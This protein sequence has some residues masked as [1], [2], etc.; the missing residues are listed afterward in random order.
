[1]EWL[2]KT[3]TESTATFKVL[4]SPVP[5]HLEAKPGQAGRDTW[6]GFTDEREEIF[7]WI[8]DDG[9]EGVVLLAADRH[10]S[11]AWVTER[12]DSYDLYEFQSSQFTNQHTHPVMEESLFGYNEKNS[13][14]LLQFDTTKDDPTVTYRIVDINGKVQESFTLKHSMLRK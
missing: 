4:V 14:G 6:A 2:Q 3:L 13:F 8:R 1:M 9:I 12:E 11:D 5:W 10:R 7:S